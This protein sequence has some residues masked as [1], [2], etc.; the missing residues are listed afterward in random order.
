MKNYHYL[1]NFLTV[2]GFLRERE[3]ERCKRFWLV[4]HSINYTLITIPYQVYHRARSYRS[5]GQGRSAE[6]HGHAVVH[7]P[8]PVLTARN[9]S[10][11][12]CCLH[13]ILW[14]DLAEEKN[15]EELK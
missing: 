2:Y 7:W 5:R 10:C 11:S 8:P 15:P 14:K 3:R 9:R 13:G 6:W 1:S 12:E 4:S